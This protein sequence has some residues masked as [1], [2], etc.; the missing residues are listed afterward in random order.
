MSKLGKFAAA[1]VAV[2][3]AFGALAAIKPPAEYQAVEYIESSGSQYINT[4]IVPKANTRVVLDFALSAIPTGNNY[5]G[6]GSQANAEVFLFGAN[7]NCFYFNVSPD[8]RTPVETGVA[9]DLERHTMDVA[10]GFQKL[11]GKQYG[12]TSISSTASDGQYLYLF[13]GRV[14]WST[15]DYWMKAKVYGC[16]IF[17]GENKVRDFVPCY[18]VADGTIGLYDTV[19]KEFFGNGG[20]SVFVKGPDQ[21]FADGLMIVGSPTDCGTVEPAYG[22]TN[23]LVV[24]ESFTCS[25]PTRA[26]DMTVRVDMVCA[27]YVVYTNGSVYAEGDG[28][29]FSY[30][31]PD[32]E[33]GAEL[34]WRWALA[35]GAKTAASYKTDGLY[36][37][38]DAIE[39]A[40]ELKH[41][42]A[43]ATW[44]NLADATHN[45]TYSSGSATFGTNGFACTAGSNS[46]TWFQG[47][48]KNAAATKSW[49]GGQGRVFTWEA[50]VNP[51]QGG[52]NSGMAGIM[53]NQYVTG[54]AAVNV[55]QYNSGSKKF[56]VGI[57]NKDS[58]SS[59][60]SLLEADV[61]FGEPLLLTFVAD[62]VN[63][64]KL[65]TNGAFYASSATE[66]VALNFDNPFYLGKNYDD[67]NTRA[68]GGTIH[69][70]RI[71]TNA[72]T[73]A[74]IRANWRVD[75]QRFYGITFED[76]L[77]IS[78][79]SE[80]WGEVTP[81]YGTTNGLAVG[82]SFLCTAPAVWTN[83]EEN[84]FATCT[85]YR[86]VADGV[87]VASG[88][89]NSFDYEHPFSEAGAKLVWQW[90]KEYRVTVG[91]DVGG[92]AT[93][94]DVWKKT[95]ETVSFTATPEEGYTF[96]GWIGNLPDE[97]DRHNP[98]V[99]MTVGA[100]PVA[101]TAAFESAE[102]PPAVYLKADATGTGTGRG[103][104]NAYTDVSNAIYAAVAAG[105]PLHVAQGVYIISKTIPLPKG[106]KVYGGFPGRSV[107]ETM[108]DRDPA[109]YQTIFTGD[110]DLDDVWVH[111]EPN[112]SF[113][114][115]SKTLAEP[116]IKDG[117]INEP[118]AFTGAYDGYCAKHNGTN[119]SIAFKGSSGWGEMNGVTISGFTS[120]GNGDGYSVVNLTGASGGV[121][122]FNDVRFTGNR[123]GYGT[124]Y[125]NGSHASKFWNC[126]FEY[127]WSGA[128][129]G[130]I[131]VHSG[132]CG[133]N[134]SNCVFKCV[135]KTA[136]DAGM[137]FNGWGGG[138]TARNCTITRCCQ[139]SGGSWQSM[140][141]GAGLIYCSESG[142]VCYLY[143]CVMTNNW[144]ATSNGYG[145]SFFAGR[146]T[147]RWKR[148]VFSHN[149]AEAKPTA[150]KA[151]SM[152]AANVD[153]GKPYRAFEACTFEGNVMRAREVAATSGGY[154][155][156]II[157][158]NVQGADSTLLNCSFKDN[159]A[160]T[161]VEKAGV[162]PV[163]CRGVLTYAPVS[164]Q[165]DETGLANCTFL[166]PKT[167]MYDVVQYGSAHDKALN[168]VNCIFE[169]D[170]DAQPV[171][172]YAEVPVLVKFYGCSILNKFSTD[173]EV[174][175]YEGLAY[176]KIPL[177]QKVVDAANGRWALQ[178]AAKVPDL[179]ETCNVATNGDSW[180]W[181]FK[182]P[183]EDSSWEALTPALA[184]LSSGKV[185]EQRLVGDAAGAARP[186]D[187]FARGALQ[188]LTE[189][190][191]NGHSLVLRREPYAAGTFSRDFSQSVAP[192]ERMEPVTATSV[193]PKLYTFAG[194]FD[195]G[196]TRVSDSATLEN[197]DLTEELTVLVGRFDAPKM[198][199]TL[200]LGECGVFDE[201]GESAMTLELAP[202][203]AFPPIPAWTRDPAWHFVG[204]D[205][206]QFVPEADT[207]YRAK[208]VS[209]AVRV[210]RVTAEGAGRMDG[211]DW[212]NAYGADHLAEA[213]AD[214][215]TYRGEL[216]LKKGLYVIRSA[217]QMIPNV[218]VRGGFAGGETSADEA[219]PTA[220]PT[221][222]SG[223]VNGDN[224]WRPDGSN[225]GAAGYEIWTEGEGGEPVFNPPNP[226]NAN[227][228]WDPA[229]N[230][231]DNTP[232]AFAN[233][234][235]NAT[236]NC[237]SGLV[238]TGFGSSA[239]ISTSGSAQGLRFE[240]CRFLACN[241]G[242]PT[243][244]NAM[245][246]VRIENSPVAMV[247]CTFDGCWNS[248]SVG[249]A[250]TVWDSFTD[251]RF[252]NCSGGGDGG[253]G[254]IRPFSSAMLAVTNCLFYRCFVGGAG[255]QGGAAISLRTGS[256]THLFADCTFEEN[257]G[258]GDGH[259]AFVFAS[260]SG[261]KLE[262]CR[263]VRNKLNNT[264]AYENR[265]SACLAHHNSGASA[266]LRDCLFDGNYL[267]STVNN[268]E[269]SPS[270]VFSAAGPVT[271]VNCTILNSTNYVTG[272]STRGGTL[273][274]W[275]SAFALVNCVIKDTVDRNGNSCELYVRSTP[276]VGI[277]NTVFASSDANYAF[278]KCDGTAM[279]P[280]VAN[281]YVQ[282]FDVGAYTNAANA[283]AYF[284]E[285]ATNGDACVRSRVE[286]G[287][288]GAAALRV[289]A[290]CPAKA[291]PVWLSGTTV[292]FYDD[293][294]NAAKPWR[295]AIDRGSYSASVSGLAL[296]SPCIPDAFGTPR[297]HVKNGTRFTCGPLYTPNGFL[298]IVR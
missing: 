39:N 197:L 152:I 79:E 7:A 162:T 236:N 24:G 196:G 230:N 168:L 61:A 225:K 217:V 68:F 258:W 200:D 238:F 10:S 69:A 106:F 89:T 82:E 147:T 179:Y 289:G 19:S 78:G 140:Y 119:T 14:E 107:S 183:G 223:D 149:V 202:G 240:R 134:I 212:D 94:V 185:F 235:G 126:R 6:W 271:M 1:C 26:V 121:Y 244:D 15:V 216:W 153:T 294:A 220:N 269:N 164:G 249:T 98:S 246:T 27:G 38:W 86:V 187:S 165:T 298:L 83:A 178:P 173:G 116:V 208:Y 247:G 293:V 252:L 233:S 296:D 17:E 286:E 57:S 48:G 23:G 280:T 28:N 186:A 154:A 273:T 133:D 102:E 272:A 129:G 191:E 266:Y 4:K 52:W 250:A 143:D 267:Y 9:P 99:E 285:V 274:S 13:A 128:R 278:M 110:R 31:H 181:A 163:L 80:D 253:A 144:C 21:S 8:W 142:G 259:G 232:N 245:G 87:T 260:G 136:A 157:G 41:S 204:F 114:L 175:T 156:G 170:G 155:L 103:W 177:V 295:N 124:V 182:R 226:N 108:A 215:G 37:Q 100:E 25:A 47:W 120:P 241:T 59:N 158:N 192:G 279:V 193:N 227:S 151:F 12:T 205:T 169:A 73:E 145:P 123:G 141:G 112:T 88:D 54:K 67:D 218:T 256:G 95:G 263:F 16:Q 292:Y 43:S 85:G 109:R 270:S 194:W 171:P 207:T 281:S 64:S 255:H 251:C 261:A 70:A 11:D 268:T 49:W 72:L 189:T 188:T 291:R 45:L 29:S 51:K 132:T 224:Y 277:V 44:V 237:F 2:L 282:G 125:M 176:D 166:G 22:M 139:A 71:Y 63:G 206:P 148:C 93:A 239:V 111:Y 221:I 65:Y 55:G 248:V 209:S 161:A 213:Y 90:E 32:C 257:R 35:P 283:N 40:G 265:H 231:G 229:G 137:I 264:G 117:R 42:A 287:P 284:Y 91:A 198:K 201:T 122:T 3:C 97:Q 30:V 135:S 203:E 211:T 190:A 105:K 254:G 53:G 101:L 50:F 127:E 150:G 74:E 159:V 130:G 297:R 288:N 262:R 243:G 58:T 34:V 138:V 210:I 20:S 242:L 167:N 60:V 36:A 199:I 276:T 118:P 290:G 160:E 77:T 104:A 84:V 96:A 219:D 18:K 115:T 62:G 92:T 228:Y 146:G 66:C 184:G 33:T 56:S 131:T 76:L 195:L 180:N 172:V 81:A 234:A 46:K 174:A 222:L 5:C 75:M 113:G 275:G 214:A